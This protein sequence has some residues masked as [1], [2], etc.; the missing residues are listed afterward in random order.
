M[1]SCFVLITFALFETNGTVFILLLFCPV[2]IH[3]WHRVVIVY[4]TLEL[5]ALIRNGVVLILT[6]CMRRI[7]GEFNQLF[8]DSLLLS[9]RFLKRCCKVILRCDFTIFCKVSI[10]CL[11]LHITGVA[12]YHTGLKLDTGI[13]IEFF[14]QFQVEDRCIIVC[15]CITG[16]LNLQALVLVIFR[17]CYDRHLTNIAVCILFTFCSFTG[18]SLLF[19][20][21]PVISYRIALEVFYNGLS[22]CV[23]RLIVWSRSS[24]CRFCI[25]FNINRN[26]FICTVFG[27]SVNLSSTSFNRSNYTVWR[28]IYNLRILCFPFH[29]F[30]TNFCWGIFYIKLCCLLVCSSSCFI[31]VL[32]CHSKYTLLGRNELCCFLR[33]LCTLCCVSLFCVCYTCC[34]H[35]LARL[36][37]FDWCTN[38]NLQRSFLFLVCFG[39]NC[40]LGSF[41]FL[42]YCLDIN[43]SFRFD[44]LS[45]FGIT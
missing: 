29:S 13:L 8:R 45:Y 14:L 19:I 5:I 34:N 16:I 11:V 20:A 41:I 10:C 15:L 22:S 33:F 6:G 1:P 32:N 26:L 2:I 42:T 38:L 37:G 18:S 25:N 28:Y 24:C 3:H 12:C 21:L 17:V 31:I 39:S 7:N 43:F 23:C 36:N 40:N 35:K 27:V 9:V 44:N 30:I 4:H